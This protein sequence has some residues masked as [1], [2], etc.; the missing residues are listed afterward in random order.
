MRRRHF[1]PFGAT[2]EPGGV[3]FRLWAPDV[4]TVDLCLDGPMGERVHPMTG[5]ADGWFETLCEEA[6]AGSRYLYRLPSG[7]KVPDPASRFQPDDVH[8]AS[9]VIDPCA[10][11]WTDTTWTGRPW[12]E[13]VIYELHAGTFTRQGGFDGVLA[14]LDHIA[15]LGVSAVELMPLAEFPGSRNWG[16]DGVMPFAP[17]GAYGRPEDLK[18]LINAAHERKLMVL[19]DVVYNHFG[20]DGNYL[21]HYAHEFFTHRH[22]TPWGDA[23]NFDGPNSRVVRD[24]FIHN[25]LYWLDEYHFDGLRLDAVHAIIDETE[26]HFLAEL[27]STVR[28]EIDDRQ[29]HLILENDRNQP[30]LLER[31]GE[32]RPKLFT[33]QWNDDFHHTCHVLATGED[34]GYY[35]DYADAPMRWLTR[36]LE[37]GFA[38]QGE[39][40]AHRGGEPR[41][42]VSGH[43][44]PGAFISFLQNHDQIGN[45][46]MGERLH[47]VAPREAVKALTAIM[48]LLP[49]PP[50]LFMGE[51]WAS[52]QPFLYFCDFHDELARAVREGRR[53]EFAGFA[54]FR[55]PRSRERIPDPNAVSSHDVSVLNW[56]E[57]AAEPYRGWLDFVHDLLYLRRRVLVPHLSTIGKPE[58]TVKGRSALRARWPLAD[59]TALE[60]HA[61]LGDRPA[62]AVGPAPG[63]LLFG[64]H[65]APAALPA[66]CATWYLG[67]KR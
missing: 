40:S 8:G 53:R 11:E 44:P 54:E 9:E 32:G 15:H 65:G 51:E 52:E 26:P 56:D 5:G 67:G 19:L 45:R 41:G 38:Y 29:V 49:F 55:D 31:D 36:V 1:M 23:I 64:T 58:V 10:F 22:R 34:G 24:F 37:S 66:W 3:R 39:A 30:E 14:K 28:R 63:R 59:G 13:A 16:Y 61:N 12:D 4:K 27:A 50:M 2:I 20:P 43:L 6:H 42:G 47:Q 7:Q 57:P 35:Q 21:G 46:A 48:L 60:L 25:A 33:A 18:R 62:D 17:D